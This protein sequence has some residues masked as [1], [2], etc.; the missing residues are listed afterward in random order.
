MNENMS[1]HICIPKKLSV[2][3]LILDFEG[4]LADTSYFYYKILKDSAENIGIE[5]NYTFCE[6]QK[7]RDEGSD[8]TKL[9]GEI[10]GDHIDRYAQKLKEIY[11]EYNT[12][13]ARL[14]PESIDV[15]MEL[16]KYGFS[17]SIYS[18]IHWSW[19][20][21]VDRFKELKKV[22]KSIFYLNR[23]DVTEPKPSTE[24]V[25]I[26]CRKMKVKPEDVAVIGDSQ[27]DIKM[28]IRAG[29]YTVGVLTGISTDESLKKAGAHAVIPRIGYLTEIL[30]RRCK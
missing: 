10:G 25:Y 14:F 5:F 20:Q 13:Y 9:I 27:I 24:G 30:E 4:T 17:I 6:V 21:L 15:L 29:S 11:W 3:G 28:G 2:K 22:Q 23:N 18:N 12:R 16:I 7:M 1:E 26:C 19:S 8:G